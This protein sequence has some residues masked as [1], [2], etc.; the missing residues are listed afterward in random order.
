M[1]VLS[2][3]AEYINVDGNIVEKDALLVAEAINDYDPNLFVICVDPHIA[4]INDAPFIIAEKGPDG[5]MRR[6]FEVWELNNSV[7]QRIEAA[8]TTRHD[9]QSKIDYVN[10]QVRGQWKKRYEERKDVWKDI[11]VTGLKHSKS[12]FTYRN[13]DTGEFTTIHEHKP[14]EKGKDVTFLSS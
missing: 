11:F 2:T 7:L 9:V 8:D 4:N 13:P 12:S 6:I 3:G 5:V 14:M 1:S 10:S